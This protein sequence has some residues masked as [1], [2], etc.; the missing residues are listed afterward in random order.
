MVDK[1]ELDRILALD[2]NEFV[3]AAYKD[4]LLRDADVNGIEY[5]SNEIRKGVSRQNILFRIMISEEALK[6]R[7]YITGFDIGSVDVSELLQYN[8]DRFIEAMYL[9]ILGRSSDESGRN[10]NRRKLSDW[11]TSKAKILCDLAF[12][13]E[14]RKRNSAVAGLD[15]EY[16]KIR[17][18]NRISRIPVLGKWYKSLCD[19]NQFRE[20]AIGEIQA[21]CIRISE[22]EAS[23][24]A[25][26]QE[27]TNR[28][29][30]IVG[31]ITELQSLNMGYNARGMSESVHDIYTLLNRE[32]N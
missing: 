7:V 15:R 16:K 27:Q 31:Q 14:G 6:K 18:R 17:R 25:M 32:D 11:Y 19:R 21:L 20:R 26:F 3:R 2:D 30:C 4:I 23:S 10:N 22:L 12:S 13:E 24:R 28:I 1:K 29:N 5:F 9:A 8:G